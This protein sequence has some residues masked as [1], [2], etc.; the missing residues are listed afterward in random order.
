MKADEIQP[1]IGK[2][3]EVEFNCYR[4]KWVIEIINWWTEVRRTSII[5]KKRANKKEGRFEDFARIKSTRTIISIT[6]LP[7]DEQLRL[8]IVNSL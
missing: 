1:F 8:R 5:F 7:K 4:R 3:C 6:E 2:I